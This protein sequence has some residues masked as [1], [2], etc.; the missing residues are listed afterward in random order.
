MKKAK[1][2]TVLFSD[3]KLN[4]IK[5]LLKKKVA[6]INTIDQEEKYLSTLSNIIN[7]IDQKVISVITRC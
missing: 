4:P 3:E 1:K 7:A 6:V 5:L 2:G